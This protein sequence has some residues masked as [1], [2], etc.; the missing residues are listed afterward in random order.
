MKKCRLC[1]Q[2]HNLEYHVEPT[3]SDKGFPVH[4]KK[5][6]ERAHRKANVAEKKEFGAKSY[7]YLKTFDR[8][9]S[10]HELAG[11][12]LKSGKIQVSKRVPQRLRKEVAFHES[13]ESDILRQSKR[14]KGK[15]N[16]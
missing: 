3:L 6:Y 15:R 8:N 13:T 1:G 4:P 5:D 14:K 16:V 9:L 11:K 7:D 2:N 12:N 10:K